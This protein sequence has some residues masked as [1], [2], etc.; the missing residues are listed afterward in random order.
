M[1]GTT[2]TTSS[3]TAAGR[4]RFLQHL[5]LLAAPLLIADAR[6]VRVNPPALLDVEAGHYQVVPAG[7][8]FCAGVLPMEGYEVV[9][10]LLRPRLPLLAGYAFIEGYLKTLGLPVQA[11]CGM[12]LRMPAPMTFEAFREFNG[13][14]V[15]QLRKWDLL[16]GPYSAVCRT[17]VAPALNPPAEP[18]LHAF[19]YVAPAR[20]RA[21]TFCVSGTADIDPRGKVVAAGS[22]A[23]A[24]MQEKIHYVL[25]VIG[26]RLSE[27]GLAWDD[28]T[29]VDFYFAVDVP[30]IWGSIILPAIGNAA[31]GGV[32]LHYARPPIVGAEVELE[33]K[34]LA[35]ELTLRT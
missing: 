9:H 25:D 31:L 21:T 10:A 4:R 29:H 14:Y 17:N 7:Q 33:A 8:V 32:R 26:E 18:V 28:V 27:M 22:T 34:G 16:L 1:K 23:P 2:L 24:A 15:E 20:G 13:P 3:E 35:R 12:E 5:S 19:S 6:A 30:D 11:V